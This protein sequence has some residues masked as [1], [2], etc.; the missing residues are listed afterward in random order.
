MLDRLAPLLRSK[1]GLNVIPVLIPYAR[2]ESEQFDVL[3]GMAA[4]LA[5]NENVVLDVTHGFRNLPMLTLVA[6]RFLARVRGVTVE[7][8]Y[9]GALE[10][11]NPDTG[12]TPVLNSRP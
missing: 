1:I 2:D 6:A 12:E 9:Y 8:I 5:D 7:N 4:H 11:T 10:M 3:R